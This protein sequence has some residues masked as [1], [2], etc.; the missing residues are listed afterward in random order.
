MAGARTRPIV[1]PQP[2]S[3]EER[4][5]RPGLVCTFYSY[6]GGVGRSMALA[7]VAVM[8]ARWGQRVLLIDWDLEA[9][10][11]ERFFGN[12]LHGSRVS[13]PGL[14]DLIS[15][16]DVENSGSGRS[17]IN[18]RD[19]LLKVSVPQGEAIDII[20]AGREGETYASQLRALNWDRLFAQG[21]GRQLE[22]IRDEWRVQYQYILID[23]R[24][25]ITDIGGICS[26]LLPDYLVSLFTTTEQS[27]LGVKETMASARAAQKELPLDR[28]RL[29]II[30]IA[31]RDESNTEYERAAEWRKRFA[32]QLSGFYDDWIHK[33]ETAESVLNYLKI[34]YVAF[35]SFG[36]SLPV[37]EEDANNP[38]TL[39]YSYALIARLIHGRLNWAE[40]KEGREATELQAQ[41]AAEV[42]TRLAEANKVRIEAI[43]RQQE[44]AERVLQQRKALLLD[45]FRELRSQS[46]RR[47][48]LCDGSLALLTLVAAGLLAGFF[49][50][51]SAKFTPD[52]WPIL[53]SS[54][55]IAAMI[56]AWPVLWRIRAARV[57][58]ALDR[59][60][61]AYTIGHGR[62]AG[63][64]SDTGLLIFADRIERIADHQD[65]DRSEAP[66]PP[67]GSSAASAPSPT[68]PLPPPPGTGTSSGIPPSPS[69]IGYDSR[70]GT[71]PFSSSAARDDHSPIDV[72]FSSPAAGISRDWAI[73]FAPLFARWLSEILGRDVSIFSS[74]VAM[75]PD[76]NW[77]EAVDRATA[78]ARTA[79]VV[80]SRRNLQSD[81]GRRELTMLYERLPP[82]CIFP[83][84]LELFRTEDVPVELSRIQWTDF[85]DVA[86]VGEG[87]AKSERYI[88]FQDRVRALAKQVAT[89]I[90]KDDERTGPPA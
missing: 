35:W 86:Y 44:E 79:I 53:A 28:Q 46:H 22:S 4:A 80:L 84:R 82:G 27:V 78:R 90:E 87:F 67:A 58:G 38:K 55:T 68:M 33:D 5:I 34:P 50:F 74:A 2:K 9:P 17:P 39:A 7:N 48:Q 16:H 43:T 24:T 73:E 47:Q 41:K 15:S 76:E 18:W 77:A 12:R 45:R 75:T 81:R 37:L 72:F 29:V 13:Q 54:L 56:A 60:Y 25:G 1:A 10:G 20:H 65:P 89:A 40:V 42:Q 63:V 3:A 6:K 69:P 70:S 8:L 30:P 31:A 14:I 23:S 49:W 85:S 51:G 61:A 11:L 64:P 83:L 36:E 88:E 62:Y 19:C 66:V 21:F 71:N 26:I 52:V 57:A 59:E 32:R